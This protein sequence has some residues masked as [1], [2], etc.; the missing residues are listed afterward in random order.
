MKI[1]LPQVG[2]SVT[3]GIIG[4]WLKNV[5]DKIEKYDPLVEVITDKV[6]MELPSPVRG[7]L[8]EIIANEGETVQMGG[9]IA[10]IETNEN[11]ENTNH[12]KLEPDVTDQEIGTTGVLLKNTA[13]VEMNPYQ[14]MTKARPQKADTLQPF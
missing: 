13:P 3:E 1:E 2:E 4:R 7:V 14:I 11:Q 12:D 6:N 5:G 9:L 8:R 10:D